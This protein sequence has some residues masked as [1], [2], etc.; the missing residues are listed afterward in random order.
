M[1]RSVFI[2]YRYYN[3]LSFVHSERLSYL[4]LYHRF[5]LVLSP[6]IKIQYKCPYKIIKLM[7]KTMEVN[8]E[9][10]LWAMTSQAPLRNN[11]ASCKIVD[12]NVSKE[13]NL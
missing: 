7:V 3:F 1:Y 5:H 13:H 10:F 2:P 4:Y 8:E 11:Q 9:T 6:A 12:L